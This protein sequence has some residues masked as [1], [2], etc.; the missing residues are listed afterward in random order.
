M[1]KYGPNK[2]PKAKSSASTTKSKG[3]GRAST[4]SVAVQL[5]NEPGRAVPLLG[6]ATLPCYHKTE[7]LNLVAVSPASIPSPDVL[8]DSEFSLYAQESSLKKGGAVTSGLHFVRGSS[9]TV[10]YMSDQTDVEINYGQASQLVVGV[11]DRTTNTVTLCPTT[12]HVIER[13]PINP[14]G[15]GSAPLTSPVGLGYHATRAALGQAFGNSKAKRAIADYEKRTIDPRAVSMTINAM[16]DN[17]GAATEL[18][19]AEAQNTSQPVIPVNSSATTVDEV[20]PLQTVVSTAELSSLDVDNLL[21]SPL[22]KRSALLPTRSIWATSMI[23]RMGSKPSI[24]ELQILVYVACLIGLFR[25]MARSTERRRIEEHNPSIPS[26]VL[27]GFYERFTQSTRSGQQPVMTFSHQVKLISH[28]VVLCL[29]LEH[30]VMDLQRIREDLGIDD[31]KM[32]THFEA[33]GCKITRKSSAHRSAIAGQPETDDAE[34]VKVAVL[35]CPP[36]FPTSRIR[37]R[38]K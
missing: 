8:K 36:T 12:A 7:R 23:S 25:Q 35:E 33:I 26:I 15:S 21:S 28:I 22:G 16:Q 14:P 30:W 34:T 3:K 20:Y 24:Q 19:S 11:Y 18:L 37:K 32:K 6:E 31:T 27:D 1:D 13:S 17:I 4:G 2:A 10:E 9:D 5:L 29:R 38:R